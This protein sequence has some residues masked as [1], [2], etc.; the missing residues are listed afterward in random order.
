MWLTIG[1]FEA[2]LL[3]QNLSH[4]TSV[5]ELEGWGCLEAYLAPLSLPSAWIVHKET[6]PECDPPSGSTM[7][8]PYSPHGTRTGLPTPHL[9]LPLLSHCQKPQDA[10]GCSRTNLETHLVPGPIY[11]AK[12]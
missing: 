7:C 8:V 4:K 11:T 3:S 6:R 9:I 10:W 5:S 1:V 12:S 2:R